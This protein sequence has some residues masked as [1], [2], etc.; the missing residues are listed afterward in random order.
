MRTTLPRTFSWMRSLLLGSAGAVTLTAC[1]AGWPAVMDPTDIASIREG[2]PQIR[3]VRDLGSV[4]IGQAGPL[5][6]ESDGVITMGELLLVEGSGFGKQPTV[7]IAGHPA[8]VRWRTA[9]GGIVLQVPLG[10]AA[11]EQTLAVEAGGRRAQAAVTLQRLGVV[12]DSRRGLLHIVQVGG[13]AAPSPTVQNV[14]QPLT[15]PGAHALAL[16]SDGAAAYVL[17]RSGAADQIAIVDLTAPG[18]PRVHDTRPLRHAAHSLLTAERAPTLAAVGPGAVTVWDIREPRRPAPWSPAELPDAAHA[19]RTAAL[20]PTGNLLALALDEGNQVL[21]FDI[22]PGRTEV[23]PR[24]VGQIAV[25]PTVKQQLLRSLRFAADGETLW[26]TSGDSAASRAFGHQPTRMTAVEVGA[27]DSASG[28][29]QLAVHKT[30]DL[31]DAGAPVQ[32]SLGR[33]APV[34]A[35]T[36]IRTPPEKTAL[37]FTAVS[38]AGLVHPGDGDSALI[39]SDLSGNT[40]ELLS[41]KELLVGLDISPDARLAVATRCRPGPSGLTVT[42]A[43]LTSGTTSTVALGP[44]DAGDLQPPFDHLTLLVQP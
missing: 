36:T 9:G 6:A 10:S 17:C 42:V 43:H 21:F 35:G 28:E 23:K 33:A 2:T 15:L 7:S 4:H 1:A 32:L 18:G 22:K 24:P 38:P 5:L 13:E 41:G 31:R 12:L 20:D 11:G 30:L 27:E 14:G 25:L 16:S 29:R 3:R 37:F 8:E 26:V 39:R 44:A 40:T 19:A 34:A